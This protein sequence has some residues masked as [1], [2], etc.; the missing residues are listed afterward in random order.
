[1]SRIRVVPMGA[2]LIDEVLALLPREVSEYPSSLVVFQGKRPGHF[3]RQALARGVGR[4]FIP[5]R[6]HTLDTFLDALYLEELGGSADEISP[7]DAVG[8][9]FALQR[10]ASP[11]IGGEHYAALESFL[12][13][14]RRMYEAFEELGDAGASPDQVRAASTGLQFDNGLLLATLYE[15]FTKEVLK[16][17]KVTRALSRSNHPVTS[18]LRVEGSSAPPRHSAARVKST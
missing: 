11:R 8:M 1:M 17:G 7:L 10:E 14:G 6:V 13:L 5:P 9:L 3:L 4:A 16:E 12:S 18:F 2:N 15:Q